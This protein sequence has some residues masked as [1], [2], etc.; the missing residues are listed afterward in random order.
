M[1]F[2]AGGYMNIEIHSDFSEPNLD[3]IKEVYTSVGWTKHTNEIITQVFEIS[4]VIA[5]V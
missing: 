5:L 2:L 4:N 3:E 1:C